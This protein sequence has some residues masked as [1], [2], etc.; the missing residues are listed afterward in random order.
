M[1]SLTKHSGKAR[2]HAIANRR[3]A[4]KTNSDTRLTVER[5][6]ADSF[7]VRELKRLGMLQDGRRALPANL[8][9]PSLSRLVGSRYWLELEYHGR[10]TPY[11]GFVSPGRG[12]TSA[13]GARGCTAHIVKP[14]R[15]YCYGALAGIAAA[16][17]LAIRCTPAKPR[18]L[19]D[20]GISRFARSGCN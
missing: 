18:A 4:G 16:P 5:L 2:S 3:L 9:W 8:R 14:E 19:A 17:V 7:D 10:D 1:P 12:V 13:A 20:V 6:S 15:R 11:S